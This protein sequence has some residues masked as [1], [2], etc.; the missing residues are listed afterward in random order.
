M[1]VAYMPIQPG[2]APVPVRSSPRDGTGRSLRMRGAHELG[3][4]CA[5]RPGLLGLSRAI[6]KPTPKVYTPRVQ[7]GGTAFWA[8]VFVLSFESLGFFSTP[9]SVSS[10]RPVRPSST[11]NTGSRDAGSR[12]SEIS[13]FANCLIE[14]S[15]PARNPSAPDS[16]D[17]M[18]AFRLVNLGHRS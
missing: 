2:D 17:V 13:R 12:A 8:D 10:Y 6:S 3:N 7:V 15:S 16:E 5:P 14:S 1:Q 18:R 11:E 9:G 4:E